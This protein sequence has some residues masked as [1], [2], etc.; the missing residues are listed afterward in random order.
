MAKR[1]KVSKSL[2]VL[3]DSIISKIMDEYELLY[4]HDAM[5]YFDVDKKIQ[6]TPLNKSAVF[7]H[8]EMSLDP[9]DPGYS[10]NPELDTPTKQWISA[11]DF[12]GPEYVAW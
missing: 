1:Q 2:P 8:I 6:R 11:W 3:P 5:A 9:N 10:F 7:T 4:E 12:C